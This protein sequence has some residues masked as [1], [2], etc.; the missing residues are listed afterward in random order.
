MHNPWPRALPFVLALSSLSTLAQAQTFSFNLPAASLASTLN[1]IASQSSQ[2]IALEPEL[3]RGKQAPAVIGQMTTEQALNTA[4][5]GSGLQLR[6]TA[7]GHFSVATVPRQDGVLELGSTRITSGYLETTTEGSGSYAAR[8]VTLGKGIHTLK[9]I[10]QSVTVITRQQLDDQGITDL[11]DALNRTTGLVG[12]QGI[13]PGMVVT[14]RGFQID[15]WQ[16]DGVPIQRNNYSL[17]NWATQDLIF[18]DRVEILRGASGLLQ[19]TGSPGGAINLVR[20]RGQ[21]SPVVSL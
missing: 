10:P 16:Y 8:A 21:A 1:R 17:G 12:A 18:F 6:V 20:K 14:S 2:I 9:E 11:K 3:V 15:D 4:L 7:S 13:G 5:A 19:G